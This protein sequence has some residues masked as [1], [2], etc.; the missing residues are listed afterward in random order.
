MDFSYTEEQTLLRDTVARFLSERYGFEARRKAIRSEA[1]RD[2]AIWRE[3]AELGL[4]GVL[5]PEEHGGLGGGPVEAMIL[6]E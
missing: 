5:V 6:M 2:P 1:G 3:F 4:L